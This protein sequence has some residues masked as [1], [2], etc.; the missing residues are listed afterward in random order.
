MAIG[1]VIIS[2]L[3]AK[4]KPLT[5][6][7][8]AFKTFR[9]IAQTSMSGLKA[10]NAQA[11]HLELP[12]VHALNCVRFLFMDSHL[13]DA[14]GP[15]VSISLSLAFLCFRSRI[16]AIRNCGIMLYTA[17]VNRVFPADGSSRTMESDKFFQKYK[18]IEEILLRTL[19]NERRQLD[20]R[21]V[22]ESVYPALDIISRL[23]FVEKN[24]VEGTNTT[25]L[26]QTLVTRHLGCHVWKI[27]EAAAKSMLA[28]T[29]PA[30][31]RVLVMMEYLITQ[32][33]KDDGR[34]NNLIHGGLC[35]AREVYEQRLSDAEGEIKRKIDGIVSD[36][37]DLYL[38]HGNNVSPI[39]QALFIQIGRNALIPDIRQLQEKIMPFCYEILLTANG[40]PPR[41]FADSLLRK[42]IA[43]TMA[44]T[45]PNFACALIS[46]DDPD[47]GI[48]LSESLAKLGINVSL[49]QDFK[50]LRAGTSNMETSTEIDG[51]GLSDLPGFASEP[52]DG[53][54]AFQ[55]VCDIMKLHQWEQYRLAAANL[56][57]LS[58]NDR[59][60]NLATLA[61]LASNDSIEPLRESAVVLLG[62]N[63]N[64]LSRDNASTSRFSS[65][66][67]TWIQ[68]LFGA[69]KDDQP[70]SSRIAALESIEAASEVLVIRP[71]ETMQSTKRD[72]LPVWIVL[73]N[74]LNDDEEEVRALA[75]D[76]AMELNSQDRSVTPLQAEK[77]IFDHL[78]TIGAAGDHEI[79]RLILVYLLGVSLDDTTKIKDQ[80]ISAN[81]PNT[82]LFKIEKQNLY[83]DECRCMRHYLALLS[84]ATPTVPSSGELSTEFLQPLVQY[85]AT[86]IETLSEIAQE[87]QV[88]SEEGGVSIDS[89]K[90]RAADGI[91]GWTTASEEI[92][93]AGI[94]IANAFRLLLTWYPNHRDTDETKE[95]VE[96]FADYG[97]R[98][99]VGFNKAWLDA[100]SV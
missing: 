96:R 99:D 57:A 65:C 27:R 58:S 26:F 73:H 87:H 12:Q 54:T 3:Q 86:G 23:T 28:F 74:L 13:S 66:V 43:K 37:A 100:F 90:L 51:T 40:A 44:V 75:S 6:L 67:Q 85:I 35:A 91:M 18:G 69:I 60:L 7:S 29:H 92:F 94:R 47:Y 2:E 49:H 5:L 95:K 22:V 1:A 16:W 17:I 9:D 15:Y 79:Q 31:D 72:L 21:L 42:E 50:S 34:D 52:E 53:T 62:K 89:G 45:F 77:V 83:R 14:I 39:N 80:L 61:E 64:P 97:A 10:L 71:G 78:A 55:T 93:V 32:D 33:F 59:A 41:S 48:A 30:Q 70:F 19:S 56:L 98:E 82:L 76:L 68:L 88:I 25:T 46:F 11:D 63:L 84:T 81:T 4:K 24:E 20:D 38:V 36:A 8:H